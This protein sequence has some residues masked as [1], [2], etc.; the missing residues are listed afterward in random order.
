[1][2]P[3][4]PTRWYSDKQEKKVAKAIGGKQTANSGATDFSKGDVTT[5]NWL[6]ECKTATSE[7]QS[8]SIKRE[9]LKKNREEA[10]SMGKDY[11]A[12]VF[13]FGDNGERYYIV[14]EKTFKLLKEVSD[15]RATEA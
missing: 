8:F 3:T 10:F 7:K 5:D 12:L 9:W 1:M 4:K 2:K 6:I 13:D 14:D 11:N 15:E